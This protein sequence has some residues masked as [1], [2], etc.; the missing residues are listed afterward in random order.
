MLLQRALVNKYFDLA[1]RG[2]TLVT[3]VQAFT[4]VALGNER[5]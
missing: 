1:S 3:E 2:C 5:D 4:P